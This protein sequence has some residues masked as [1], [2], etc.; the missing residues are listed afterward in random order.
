MT[1]NKEAYPPHSRTTV[2]RLPNRGVYDYN[3][4]HSILDSIPILHVSFNPPTSSPDEPQFPVVL[5]MLGSIG[6]FANKSQTLNT[7]PQCIYLHGSSAARMMRLGSSSESQGFPVTVAA[8]K[9]DGY[10]LALT[11]FNHSCNYR[12][13]VVNGLAY[14]VVDEEEKMWALTLITEG[15]VKGRWDGSRVPPTKAEMTATG[16]LRVEIQT[17]SAKIREGGPHDDKK[18]LRDHASVE[19]VWTGV[20]PAWETVGDPVASETNK[21]ERVPQYLNEW[22]EEMRILNEEQA[23]GAA[24]RD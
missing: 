11:P 20:V 3:T 7:G 15:I 19:R 8:T 9:L 10:V 6:N 5:P 22:V 1:D 24:L 13:A 4:I 12:S 18:D 2:K 16:V 17:G 21:V 14:E 23:V